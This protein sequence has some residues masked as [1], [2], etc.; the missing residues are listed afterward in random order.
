MKTFYD[1]SKLLSYNAVYNFAVGGRGIGKTY[2]AKKKV[3]RDAIK[4]SIENGDQ[5]IY[6]RRYKKELQVSRDTF[7][8]DYAHEFP[9]YDFR[10]H[11]YFAQAAPV[12]TRDDKKREWFT[13]GYF[14]ALSVAQS[15]KSVAFPRVK[16][17]IYDEFIIEKGAI[18]YLPDEATVFNNF[19]STVDRYKDKTRVFFLANSVMITNPYFIE[20]DIDPNKCDKNGII[21]LFDGFILVHI[22]DS[23]QFSN[24]VYETRFGK[25]IRGTDYGNYAVGNEFVDNNDL[26]L[27]D[28][29]SSAVYTLTLETHGATFSIWYDASESLYYC[30]LKR[31]GNEIIFTM[32]PERMGEDKTLVTFSDKSI[33]RLRTAYRHGKMRFKKPAIRNAFMETFKR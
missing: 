11:S 15:Y 2:G 23:E 26:L 14:I 24:E 29:P 5:F 30:D 32:V 31:P 28:K 4:S 17:I 25:F 10:I 18:H 12:S 27:A 1:F 20:Y 16:I 9:D 6:L 3:T 8:A 19:F 22:I 21:K 7:F 33:S 13:I